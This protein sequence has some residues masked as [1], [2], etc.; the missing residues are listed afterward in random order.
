MR[1]LCSP[2]APVAVAAPC[3]VPWA[4]FFSARSSACIAVTGTGPHAIIYCSRRAARTGPLL[5]RLLL[6]LHGNDRDWGAFG[7]FGLLLEGS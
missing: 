1:H 5:Q 4:R 2:L 3:L 7:D 6:C